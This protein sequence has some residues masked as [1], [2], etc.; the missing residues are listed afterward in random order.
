MPVDCRRLADWGL[1]LALAAALAAPD[2]PAVAQPQPVAT[3]RLAERQA[4]RQT[5]QLELEAAERLLRASSEAR[6]RLESEVAG[7]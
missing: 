2:R 3:E 7:L 5:R 1:G 6:A 4:E